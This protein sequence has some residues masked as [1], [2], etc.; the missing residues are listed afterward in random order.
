MGKKQ[1]IPDKSKVKIDLG[2]FTKGEW[3]EVGIKNHKKYQG[4]IGVVTSLETYTELGDKDFEYY[5]V[6]VQGLPELVGI[7]GY[8][9]TPIKNGR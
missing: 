1:S 5:N 7:S 4:K 3:E 2:Q 9:L 8:H 6:T